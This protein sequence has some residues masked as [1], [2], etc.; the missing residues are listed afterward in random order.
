MLFGPF[1]W[2]INIEIPKAIPTWLSQPTQHKNDYKN[3]THIELKFDV[4]L[5]EYLHA[6]RAKHCVTYFPS[7]LALNF[8]V[9]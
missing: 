3:V 2:Q 8:G 7:T 4:V 6:L 9:D 5:A 1:I